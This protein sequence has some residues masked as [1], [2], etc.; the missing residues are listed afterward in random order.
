MTKKSE[1]IQLSGG[2]T[3]KTSMPMKIRSG[4]LS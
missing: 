2:K 4:I 1:I 3:I